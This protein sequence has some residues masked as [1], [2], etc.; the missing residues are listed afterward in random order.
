MCFPKI[1][2]AV[3]TRVMVSSSQLSLDE[4]GVIEDGFI[5]AAFYVW[6]AWAVSC[7]YARVARVVVLFSIIRCRA[8]GVTAWR[9]FVRSRF[10]G[11]VVR[12]GCPWTASA[13][14]VS[15]DA[16]E[17]RAPSTLVKW[18]LLNPCVVLLPPPDSGLAL[19]RT[20]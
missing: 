18:R 14:D 11:F 2:N 5:D 15:F 10:F 13:K 16:S 4:N 17:A 19:F 3:L 9:G 1:A 8:A 20:V 7:A 6:L 12:G